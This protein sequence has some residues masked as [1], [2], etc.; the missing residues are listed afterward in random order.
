MLF[1]LQNIER[2]ERLI[3][4]EQT[5]YE[6]TVKELMNSLSKFNECMIQLKISY[7]YDYADKVTNISQKDLGEVLFEMEQIQYALKQAE[8]RSKRLEQKLKT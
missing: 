4:M 3:K 1:N 8:K 6:Q 2:K 7:I 5:K